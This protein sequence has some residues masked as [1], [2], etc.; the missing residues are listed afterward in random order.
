MLSWG[1][2]M[3]RWRGALSP[4]LEVPMHVLVAWMEGKLLL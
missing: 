4:G 2:E 1:P 3:G